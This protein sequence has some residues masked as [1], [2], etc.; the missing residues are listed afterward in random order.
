MS[1]ALNPYDEGTIAFRIWERNKNNNNIEDASAED[2][3]VIHLRID[4]QMISNI[5][6][7]TGR[8]AQAVR[9][10]LQRYSIIPEKE[11]PA[12]KHKIVKSNSEMIVEAL[13]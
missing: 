2:L 4:G 9:N 8:S 1:N 3:K 5:A 13:G 7:L 6:R 10:V 12:E 11:A